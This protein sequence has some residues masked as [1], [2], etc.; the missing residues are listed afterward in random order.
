ML[1]IIQVMC[2]VFS[3]DG[4][5]VRLLATQRA[6]VNAGLHGLDALGCLA[7]FGWAV[8]VGDGLILE[9]HQRLPKMEIPMQ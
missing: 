7:T 8:D 5:M 4:D 6:D 9:A 2:A 1:W 3:G